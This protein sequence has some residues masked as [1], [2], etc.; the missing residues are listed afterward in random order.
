MITN[1]CEISI[2]YKDANTLIFN[3]SNSTFV[4][5]NNAVINQIRKSAP[6]SKIIVANEDISGYLRHW[7][8]SYEY[9]VKSELP[10]MEYHRM[11]K[12]QISDIPNTIKE[13]EYLG[14]IYKCLNKV[15]VI[16]I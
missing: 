9:G 10:D 2:A 5:I 11:R 6:D 3:H 13:L 15:S 8:L 16:Q 4:L 1:L 7:G 14:M 12:I